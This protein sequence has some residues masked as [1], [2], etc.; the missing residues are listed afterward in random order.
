MVWSEK[1]KA[2]MSKAK[3]KTNPNSYS[4]ILKHARFD[5]D[6]C[7]DTLEKIVACSD[8][9]A[10]PFDKMIHPQDQNDPHPSS[11]LCHDIV[12]MLNRYLKTVNNVK[13]C[14]SQ[15]QRLIDVNC[16]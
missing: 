12:N 15:L 3:Q 5:I 9:L 4:E 14:F 6:H 16:L 8:S 11:S 7:N 1:L 10:A 2:C 13:Q